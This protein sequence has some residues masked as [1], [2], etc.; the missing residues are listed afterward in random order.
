M[1]L[2]ES[3]GVVAPGGGSD[4]PVKPAPERDAG[5]N[6]ELAW[7]ALGAWTREHYSAF[8][9]LLLVIVGAILSPAFLSIRNL[10]NIGL[11]TSIFGLVTLAE[12][13]VVLTRGIDI[14]VGSVVGLSG[15]LGAGLF[16]GSN[17][18]VAVLIG[19]AVGAL[20]GV[21]NGYLIAFR[22]LEPFIVT[23]G[24]LSLARGLVYVY[25]QG[26]PMQPS[27]NDFATV[28]NVYVL[29]IPVEFLIWVSF[30]LGVAFVLRH[31]VFGRRVYAVGSSADASR[32]AG[33]PVRSTLFLVYV[34][35]GMLSGLAGFLLAAQVEVGTPT[36]GNLYEL[37]AIAG[38][39]IGGTRLAGGKGS[40]FNTVVGT[41]I[42]G[43][44]TNLLVL[45]NINTFETEAFTGGLI[46]GVLFLMSL[47]MPR[48]LS[49]NSGRAHGSPI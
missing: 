1:E 36:G 2:N 46:L 34:I 26:M 49:G 13:L 11:Q 23:L 16:G 42:F 40:V 22:A 39:V 35:S 8:I 7:Q 41:L 4:P 5:V 30:I 3:A 10:Q 33:V 47:R 25:T 19:I 9:L 44:I 20:V 48:W 24:M 43:G 21:V 12:F 27:A 15:V 28:A 17:V 29:G 38:V 37:T 31:T 18:F 14:S 45:L 32:A 6:A